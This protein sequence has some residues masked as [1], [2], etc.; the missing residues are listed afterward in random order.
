[1]LIFNDISVL[2]SIANGIYSLEQH[3]RL[4]LRH[5]STRRSRPMMIAT[6]MGMTVMPMMMMMTMMMIFKMLKLTKELFLLLHSTQV[7]DRFR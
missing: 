7:K 1:M 3:R 5:S 6:M 2:Y 4:P